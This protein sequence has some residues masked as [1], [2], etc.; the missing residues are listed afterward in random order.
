MSIFNDFFHVKQSPILSMLGFGGGGT[1]TALGGGGASFSASGGNA[2][3]ELNGYKYHVFTS[4]G[5]LVADAGVPDA[6]VEF[7]VIGG[8]GGAGAGTNQDYGRGGGGGGAGGLRCSFQGL[9]P[10]GPSASAENGIT[11]TAGTTYPVTVGDGGSGLQGGSGSGPNNGDDSS[12][13]PPSSS[14][15]I[16]AG[17][18][19]IGSG[20]R[21]QNGGA[22]NGGSGGGASASEGASLLGGNALAAPG[23]NP[24]NAGYAGGGTNPESNICGGGGGAGGVG[25]TGDYPN[26]AGARYGKG[27]SG[28]P[29]P[30]NMIPTS[31]GRSSPTGPGRWFAQGG[32][33]EC[34]DQTG[35]YVDEGGAG[36]N[37]HAPPSA[38][39]G[40]TING[41]ANTGSGGGGMGDGETGGNGGKG[42]VI[43]R[44]LL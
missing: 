37:P 1:G 13:G 28:M 27:G 6:E 10:G 41:V 2:E 44:Y 12:W 14:Q 21:N 8:G 32:Y 40:D 15:R 11:C 23:L 19:G 30:T 42:I 33:G 39:R 9:V 24:T 3:Y 18:G 38:A 34:L 26:G 4:S 43:L 31:Y 17:G 16:V 35:P 7:L 5:S 36:C 29:I 25:Q 22:S 20:S